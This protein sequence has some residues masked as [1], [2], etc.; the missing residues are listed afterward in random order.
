MT[1]G[2]GHDLSTVDLLGVRVANATKAQAVA[3]MERW[4][5]G[6]DGRTHLVF[7][8]NAHTLN[9]AWENT[10]Y[11]RVLDAADVVFADGTGARLAA[12]WRG[13]R[14]QDN[15]VG[16]DLVPAFFRATAERGLRYFLLG[17]RP[18][19]PERA[20]AHLRR[21]FPGIEVA[22]E[23][24]GY[25]GRDDAE[26]VIA[27]VNR[28]RPDVL[29]VGMGNP[30]QELFLDRHRAALEVPVAV[31]V[32]GLFDHWAG[33]LHRAPRWVRRLGA[34]WVQLLLQQPHKWRRYLLGNPRFVYRAL[35]CTVVGP[36]V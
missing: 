26:R 3:L 23:H 33:H 13:V 7:I 35:R 8:A 4:V 14:L 28:A 31:G 19:T 5:R 11:R 27:L 6:G 10:G 18:G 34:E 29:L 1:S 15:L 12:R 2:R 32:G 36:P 16:T 22:G 30:A 9:L 25:V 21:D 24:H 20:S 17:G